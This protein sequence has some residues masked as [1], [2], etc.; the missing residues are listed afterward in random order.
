MTSERRNVTAPDGV[1]VVDVRPQTSPDD[2]RVMQLWESET[3]SRFKTL[4]RSQIVLEA[5]FGRYLTVDNATEMR[6]AV[7][8]AEKFLY[9]AIVDELCRSQLDDDA[10]ATVEWLRSIGAVDSADGCYIGFPNDE[11]QSVSFLLD[12][13]APGG[14]SHCSLYCSDDGG[15]IKT[16]GDVRRLCAA[17]GLHLHGS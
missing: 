5:T 2:P 15:H 17:L 8:Q 14:W 12:D 4:V 1:N 13:D 7:E 9:A 11:W 16:R 3:V 6:V 10:R